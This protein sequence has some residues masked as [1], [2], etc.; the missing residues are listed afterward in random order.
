[1]SVHAIVLTIALPAVI[2]VP[3]LLL[4]EDAAGVSSA[5]FALL[6]ETDNVG[7]VT[8]SCKGNAWDSILD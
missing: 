1:M 2:F 7:A 6:L 8:R 4:I 5:L 3:V